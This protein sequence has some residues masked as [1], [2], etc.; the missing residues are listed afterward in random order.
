MQE[1]KIYDAQLQDQR[2][3]YGK[4]G[5]KS[6]SEEETGLICLQ[7]IADQMPL[8]KSRSSYDEGADASK[9]GRD[10]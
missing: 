4:Q 10:H 2:E 7:I 9:G 5:A 3:H 1:W 8:P 6:S